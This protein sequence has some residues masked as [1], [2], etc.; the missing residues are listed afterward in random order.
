MIPPWPVLHADHST[1]TYDDT[2]TRP[3]IVI[4]QGE[5]GVVLTGDTGV[6]VSLLRLALKVLETPQ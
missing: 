2:F 3:A 4:H 6:L 1:V 5:Q